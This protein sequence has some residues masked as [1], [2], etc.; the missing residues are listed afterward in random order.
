MDLNIF[1]QSNVEERTV[2]LIRH[3]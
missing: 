1:F 3:V 2:R